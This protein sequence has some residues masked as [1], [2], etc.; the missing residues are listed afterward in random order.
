MP[1]SLRNHPSDLDT[2]LAVLHK[3]AHP[4]P[5]SKP[6]CHTRQLFG[7]GS[8]FRPGMAIRRTRSLKSPLTSRSGI[9]RATR[10]QLSDGFWSVTLKIAETRRHSSAQM[11]PCNLPK[12]SPSSY[13]D[14]RSKSPSQKPAP[15]SGSKR[16]ANGPTKLSRAQ[17]PRC[18]VYTVSL[19]FGPAIF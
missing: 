5:N 17:R 18:S 1:I 6:F 3:K 19:R 7:T 11:S 2:A 4:C 15:I 10:L 16:S 12:S 14:G 9:A 13:G 8:A